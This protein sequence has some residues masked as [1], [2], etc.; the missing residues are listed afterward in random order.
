MTDF[1]KENCKTPVFQKILDLLCYYILKIGA[2]GTNLGYLVDK[3]P[4]V[5]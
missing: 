4:K 3:I 2:R 1:Q 5:S